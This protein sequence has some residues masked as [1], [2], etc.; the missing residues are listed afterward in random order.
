[1]LAGTQ[2]STLT[3]VPDWPAIPTPTARNQSS[4][5]A[6]TKCMKEPAESTI[7]RCHPGLA[8]NERG[9][10]AGSTSSILLIPVILTNPPSGSA[11]MPYSVSP[12]RIDHSVDPKPTKNCV[13]FMP[14]ALAV[15]KCPASCS[16][17][18]TSK[19]TTKMSTP[20]RKLIVPT[21]PPGYV[22]AP[23]RAALGA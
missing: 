4:T 20:I 23:C 7:A 1:L 21:L 6:I 18:E 9:S 10:S 5:K 19:A 13:A 8:R 16:M 15:R 2:R 3:V 17:T 14:K 11:L 12:R 22:R